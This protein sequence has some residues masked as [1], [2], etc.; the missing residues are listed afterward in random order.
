M[1][2]RIEGKGLHMLNTFW[3][4]AEECGTQNSTAY[5]IPSW[6]IFQAEW[7]QAT[8]KMDMVWERFSNYLIFQ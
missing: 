3:N 6:N 8:V 7:L 4:D 2:E 1:S 5:N